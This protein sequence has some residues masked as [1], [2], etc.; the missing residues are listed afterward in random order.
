M[1]LPLTVELRKVDDGVLRVVVPAGAPFDM[2]LPLEVAAGNLANDQRSVTVP[3][4]ALQS[5]NIEVIRDSAEPSPVTITFGT[6]PDLPANH[7]GYAIT[8]RD[9]P[10]QVLPGEGASIL[11]LIVTARHGP[12]GI[13]AELGIDVVL[14]KNVT[15]DTTGGIP[16]VGIDIGGK[17]KQAA[18]AS[19][20][21]TNQLEFRYAV[22]AGDTDT[23]GISVPANAL[24]TNGGTIQAN[25]FPSDLTHDAVATI[26]R[27]TVDGIVPTLLSSTVEHALVTLT[28]DEPIR[29]AG[30]AG[31]ASFEYEVDGGASTTV[32]GGDVHER[33]VTLTL[34]AAVTAGQVVDLE[35]QFTPPQS[36]IEDAA[37]NDVA[38]FLSQTLDNT[39]DV[40]APTITSVVINSDP[41]EDMRDGNDDTY[42]IGDTVQVVITFDQAMTV[43]T[44][45]GT[46][47]LEL[48]I[49]GKPR[50]AL[51]S[52]TLF[53]EL[54]FTYTVAEG[55]EDTNGISIGAN[56][57]SANGAIIAS[58]AKNADLTHNAQTA[59]GHK[60]D[61]IRPTM[62][63]AV[64][65]ADGM[66]HHRHLQRGDVIVR[67][68][69]TPSGKTE[70]A[71]QM[72][73]INVDV[74]G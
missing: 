35:H 65:S 60:V 64:S 15:V 33:T 56:K 40:A 1:T 21:G 69:V 5:E 7:Q 51:Y 66:H 61:G 41:N 43:N 22:Q 32:C 27:A 19:G 8:T 67:H 57:L 9:G 18:Y 24:K 44:A 14:D 31:W 38:A 46:P 45:G 20:G 58:S 36:H 71:S 48:D 54:S 28:F 59:P 62:T 49:G 29:K 2:V 11:A 72:G 70:A 12:F 30:N 74:M 39:T 47:E 42:A 68:R 53:R 73:T 63:N 52:G 26:P 23:D 50:N 37:G 25:A 3:A 13:S 17:T 16:Y 10:F 34:C 55:D 6:L 4:G